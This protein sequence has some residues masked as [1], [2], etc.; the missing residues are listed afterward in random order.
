[1]LYYTMEY[2]R[3]HTLKG[4]VRDGGAQSPARVRHILRQVLKSLS[5]A[6]SYGIVHR[7]LKP[8]N[9]MLVDMH[10]ETDFVKVL[11]FGIAKIM[12]AGEDDESNPLH[13]DRYA[14][15]HAALHGRPN[16]SA[17]RRW[18]PY[19]D[20]YALG[21]DRVGDALGALRFRGD[22]ALGGAAKTGQP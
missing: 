7:D 12:D 14:R 11:D 10:G 9:I 5:E 17:A 8:A 22:R 3:G 15:G 2:L 21:A 20:L 19:T 13:L 1:M 18:G 4:V 6:H 16:R